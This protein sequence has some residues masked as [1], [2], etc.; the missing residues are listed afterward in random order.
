MYLV[1][2]LYRWFQYSGIE[3]EIKFFIHYRLIKKAG[4]LIRCIKAIRIYTTGDRVV[5]VSR[6]AFIHFCREE[7][8]EAIIVGA[9]GSRKAA[10]QQRFLEFDFLQDQF[11]CLSHQL[12]FQ[13]FHTQYSIIYFDQIVYFLF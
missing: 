11:L 2:D 5:P 6:I 1:Q 12:F 3:Y 9:I 4:I 10:A 8:F 13:L 7:Y